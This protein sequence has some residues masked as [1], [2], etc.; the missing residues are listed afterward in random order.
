[1]SKENDLPVEVGVHQSFDVSAEKVFDAW[2]DPSMVRQWMF[3]P[4]LREENI[5]RIECGKLTGDRFSFLVE[6]NGHSIDHVGHYLEVDRPRRLVFTWGIAPVEG[7]PSVV[8]IALSSTDDK[9]CDLALKHSM[10]DD[11]REYA[12]RTRAAWEKMLGVLAEVIQER[13][14]TD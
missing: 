11:W 9:H 2:L 7:T 14:S 13:D 6:R 1:L 12:D 3:G 4:R 5:V 8:S 10:T